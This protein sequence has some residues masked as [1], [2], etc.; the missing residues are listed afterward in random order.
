MTVAEKKKILGIDWE[1]ILKVAGI[2]LLG[3]ALLGIAVTIL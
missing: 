3:I 1:K 2:A